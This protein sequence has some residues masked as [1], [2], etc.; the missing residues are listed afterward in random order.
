MA[1]HMDSSNHWGQHKSIHPRPLPSVQAPASS[2][3]ALGLASFITSL[4][5]GIAMLMCFVLASALE[6]SDAGLDEALLTELLGLGM[7]M[8]MFAQLVAAGLGIAALTQA[9][10]KRLFGVLGTVFSVSALLITLLLMGLG[11]V[12]AEI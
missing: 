5:A 6:V 4:F 1:P 9:H 10:G 3:S 11:G 12:F 8:L 7:A 2:A